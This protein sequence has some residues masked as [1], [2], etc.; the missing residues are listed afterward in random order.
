M[1]SER[2]VQV[3]KECEKAGI[4]VVAISSNGTLDYSTHGLGDTEQF[5]DQCESL[6]L[7]PDPDPFDW[8][9]DG[10]KKAVCRA[11]NCVIEGGLERP[12]EW[13][14]ISKPLYCPK[15]GRELT[16]KEKEE[17]AK[18]LERDQKRMNS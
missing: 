5:C 2:D 17:A 4:G 12:S 9:R 8:F 7:E 6:R 11:L 13:T 18:Q 14:K 10:D 1:L 16:E 15:L 3:I